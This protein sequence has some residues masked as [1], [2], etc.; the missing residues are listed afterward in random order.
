MYSY[1]AIQPLKAASVLNKIISSVQFSSKWIQCFIL[2]TNY[3]HVVLRYDM[4]CCINVRS[5]ADVSQRNLP[6]GTKTKKWKKGKIKNETRICS[7]ASVSSRGESVES[8]LKKTRK[9]TCNHDSHDLGLHKTIHCSSR[10]NVTCEATRLLFSLSP[11]SVSC[12]PITP[13]WCVNVDCKTKLL[14][15][16]FD[17]YVA[18]MQCLVRKCLYKLVG[19]QV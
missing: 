15:R 12:P 9:A 16:I 8:V 4:R 11:Y 6:H 17:W 7:Q 18:L 10:P 14:M 2:C 3:L 5:K 1:S 19:L 13:H